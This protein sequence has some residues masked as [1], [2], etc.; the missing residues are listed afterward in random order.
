MRLYD[1]CEP[2]FRYVC[3]VNRSARAGQQPQMEQVRGKVKEILAEIESQASSDHLMAE[4]FRKVKLP[5]IYFVDSL[6][7]QSDL[8]FATRWDQERLAYAYDKLAGDEEFFTRLDETLEDQSDEA[9]ERLMIYY[10][11][12]GLGFTGMYEGRE[13][14]IDSRMARV[15]GRVKQHID[16]DPESQICPGAY[17]VDERDLTEAPG[18][19]V[20]T[21]LFFLFGLLF[22]FAVGYYVVYQTAVHDLVESLDTILKAG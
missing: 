13:Q 4:Q 9:T 12:L 17:K 2:L 3:A 19:K 22:V 21:I 18:Q 5:L 10:A 14:Q 20:T 1:L 16:M 11:C 7:V 8:D 15:A 6:I